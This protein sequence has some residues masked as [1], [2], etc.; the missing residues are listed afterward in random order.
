[1]IE[2]YIDGSTKGSTGPSGA[3]IHM[4]Y[5]GTHDSY[6][7]PLGEMDNHEAEFQ[8]LLHALKICKEKNFDVISVRTDSQAVLTAVEKQYV[9]NNAYKDLLSE[10]LKISSSFTLFFIKWIPSSQNNVADR[11]AREAISQNE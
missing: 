2:V 9:K 8:A 4:K 5:N 1:M 11:L 6:S 10:I 3:G 7:I